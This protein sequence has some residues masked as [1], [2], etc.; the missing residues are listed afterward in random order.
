M[1]WVRYV[2]REGD[3]HYVTNDP[4]PKK[5]VDNRRVVHYIIRERVS[6]ICQREDKTLFIL[7]GQWLLVDIQIDNAHNWLTSYEE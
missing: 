7:D 6:A 2:D 1:D 3:T 4:V 5:L